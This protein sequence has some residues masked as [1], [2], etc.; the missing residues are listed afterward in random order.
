MAETGGTKLD[1]VERV[2]VVK[3]VSVLDVEANGRLGGSSTG[4]NA[5]GHCAFLFG[6]SWAGAG[7]KVVVGF[8]AG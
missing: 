2:E 4:D 6:E 3:G 8:L 5:I 7:L 1:F